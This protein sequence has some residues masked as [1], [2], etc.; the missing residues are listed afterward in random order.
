MRIKPPLSQSLVKLP[1]MWE[2]CEVGFTTAVKPRDQLCG[3]FRDVST[4]TA[5]GIQSAPVRNKA[6]GSAV[7][8]LSAELGTLRCSL[9]PWSHSSAHEGLLPNVS[10]LQ[11]P[12]T[13]RCWRP[14]RGADRHSDGFWIQEFRFRFKYRHIALAVCVGVCKFCV[15]LQATKGCISWPSSIPSTTLPFGGKEQ[16]EER[17]SCMHISSKRADSSCK[18]VN[19]PQIYEEGWS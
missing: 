11:E 1:W 16:K 2:R 10:H 9:Q 3:Y 8:Q 12:L 18:Q 4:Q 5:E 19:D 15:C 14:W 13:I 17:P 7:S 6:R